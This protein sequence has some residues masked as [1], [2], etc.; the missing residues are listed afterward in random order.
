MYKKQIKIKGKKYIY[1]YHNFKVDGKVK[2][3][4]LSNK[5]EEALKKLETIINK[6][7]KKENIMENIHLINY[8]KTFLVVFGMLLLTAGLY[9]L[10]PS[11]SS[12][13]VYS[14][15]AYN[16]NNLIRELK[17]KEFLGIIISLQI[18]VFGYYLRRDFKD[19]K[20]KV[21]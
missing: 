1:Y 18:M 11:I 7:M 8:S 14:N 6:D 15:S 20:V 13:V 9:Y 10:S 17:L 4:F 5:K 16:I 12:F 21:I 2:N 3:V 19:K